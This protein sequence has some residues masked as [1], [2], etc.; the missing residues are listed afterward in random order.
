MVYLFFNLKIKHLQMDQTNYNSAN[1]VRIQRCVVNICWKD[2][3]I[4]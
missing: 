2:V 4:L 3:Y 1:F